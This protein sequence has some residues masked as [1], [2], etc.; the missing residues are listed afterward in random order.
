LE[1]AREKNFNRTNVPFELVCIS[2]VH[3]PSKKF[4]LVSL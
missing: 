1:T 4:G 3:L 2:S